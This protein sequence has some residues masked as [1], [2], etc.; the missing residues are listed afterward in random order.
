MPS[1][2]YSIHSSSALVKNPG[3]LQLKMLIFCWA[4]IALAFDGST[5]IS[6]SM[7]GFSFS[8]LL[9]RIVFSLSNEALSFCIRNN[10]SGWPYLLMIRP[11]LTS[12]ACVFETPV[13]KLPYDNNGVN[14]LS[15]VMSTSA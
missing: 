4:S 2:D 15:H 3:P 7:T 8:F 1:L 6:I 14:G 13:I 12:K 5:N 10:N 11:L 9:L